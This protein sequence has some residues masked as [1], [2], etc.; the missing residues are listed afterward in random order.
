MGFSASSWSADGRWLSGAL[1]QPDGQQVPG[2]VLYSLAGRSYRRITGRGQAATWLSDSR[3]FLYWI[4]G[5]LFLFD[6][7]SGTSRQVL[8][9]PPGSDYNDFSLSPDDRVLYLA[10]NT[11]QGDI[12]LLTLR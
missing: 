6:L 8:G 3:H 9:T 7:R 11:E 1:H 12:W 10:H 5:T 2:V 4:G